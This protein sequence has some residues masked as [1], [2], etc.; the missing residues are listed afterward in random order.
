MRLIDADLM[1]KRVACDGLE[2][3]AERK[4]IIAIREWIDSQETVSSDNL[5]NNYKV[6]PCC[7][8]EL[9][10]NGVEN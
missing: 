8:Q 5:N 7:G 3:P 4:R 2:T 6:C 1:K 9:R 10:R